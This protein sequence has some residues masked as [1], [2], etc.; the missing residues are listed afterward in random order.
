MSYNYIHF[1]CEVEDKS[2]SAQ[3]GMRPHASFWQIENLSP[4]TPVLFDKEGLKL[5]KGHGRG[6]AGSEAPGPGAP[7][8]QSVYDRLGVGALL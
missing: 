2:I 1:V 7:N 4:S 3:F 5:P 8:P 6:P